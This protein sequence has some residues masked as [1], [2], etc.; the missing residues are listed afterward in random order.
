MK[1]CTLCQIVS[2]YCITNA[3]CSYVFAVAGEHH[4][5]LSTFSLPLTL[6]CTVCF[7][8]CP[9]ETTL[10]CHMQEHKQ[11]LSPVCSKVQ[12][13]GVVFG[14]MDCSDWFD[15]VRDLTHH[16][17]TH[18]KKKKTPLPKTLKNT[19][20]NQQT[21]KQTPKCLSVEKN[22]SFQIVWHQNPV[23]Q[24]PVVEKKMFISPPA[25]NHSFTEDTGAVDITECITCIYNLYLSEHSYS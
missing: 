19:A 25:V 4:L 14:C 15:T 3:C 20:I 10:L 7:K 17:K 6:T 24:N 8:D 2:V 11:F 1:C 9:S 13:A 23:V 21:N 12:Y 16:F 22:P 5:N 18:K